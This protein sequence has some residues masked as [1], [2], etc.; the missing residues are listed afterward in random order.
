MNYRNWKS[1]VMAAPIVAGLLLL[2]GCEDTEAR[3]TMGSAKSEIADLKNQIADLKSKTDG[4]TSQLSAAKEELRT[5]MLKAV[6]QS[7]QKQADQVNN[8]LDKLTKLTEDTRTLAREITDKSRSDFDN[9]LKNAKLQWAGDLQKL[10]D[11]NAKT[12]DDLKKFMDN[13]L[14]EL[15]PYAYQ[16]K[17][18][19]SNTPPAPETK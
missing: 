19:D 4:L 1:F 17:R 8:L 10:R 2:S 15:Y 5:A 18:L 16:P 3:A 12:F 6:D 13:Q 9:E 11:D 7:S 14:R